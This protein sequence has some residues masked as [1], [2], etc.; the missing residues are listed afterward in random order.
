MPVFFNTAN[1]IAGL[2]FGSVGFVAFT[3]GKRMSLWTPMFY[4]L[5]LM[6]FPYF[7]ESPGLLL[8]IGGFG[9]LG[10]FFLRH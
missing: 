8:I 2:L 7:V 6:A 4:G 9:I 1:L 10:L 5:A 3:Y